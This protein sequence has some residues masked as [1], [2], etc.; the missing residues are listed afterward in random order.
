MTLNG[1]TTGIAAGTSVVAYIRP[2][3]GTEA[4]QAQKPVKITR[5][6]LTADTFVYRIT[7][8][9]ARLTYQVYV[10]VDGKQSTTTTVRR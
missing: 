3:G 8:L 7:G 10:V 5:G 2:A 1:R 4:F 9:Q 6:D